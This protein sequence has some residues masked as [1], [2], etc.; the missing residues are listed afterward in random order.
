MRGE[1]YLH[2]GQLICRTLDAW[3]VQ[4]RK[5]CDRERGLCEECR[6]EAPFTSYWRRGV[7]HP[8]GHARH[9]RQAVRDDRWF[10]L[11]WLCWR[12]V[13]LKT[14]TRWPQRVAGRGRMFA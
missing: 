12:G 6:V 9:R 7:F 3:R 4:A 11:R 5:A 1:V 14:G 10:H 8:E 2:G 13:Q